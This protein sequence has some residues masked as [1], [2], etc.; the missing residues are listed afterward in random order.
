MR[1]TIAFLILL[2]PIGTP[3]NAQ[4]VYKCMKGRDVSY[5]SAP[6][7]RTQ[8]L[9]KQWEP[10]PEPEPD[11]RAVESSRRRATGRQLGASSLRERR[12]SGSHGKAAS[13]INGD[14]NRCEAAKARRHAKLSALGLKRSFDLLRKLDEAVREACK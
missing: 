11:P 8:R 5:Q 1:A 3:A 10:S 4:Q 6:C 13:S 12:H 9:V 14:E 2:M 7:G